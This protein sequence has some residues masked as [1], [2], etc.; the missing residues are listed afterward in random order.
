MFFLIY[1]LRLW[2]IQFAV[3]YNKEKEQILR[4]LEAATRE[5]LAFLLEK[6]T[7]MIID[8]QNN[9]W[10]IFCWSAN[11]LIDYL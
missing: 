8:C 6:L 7:E 9:C 10:L 1:S 11:Q 5:Y 4:I 3:V 2:D